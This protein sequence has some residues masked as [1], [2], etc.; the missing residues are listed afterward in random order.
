MSKIMA[1]ITITCRYGN[2]HIAQDELPTA[3]GVD[4]LIVLTLGAY[5]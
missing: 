1:E 3:H 5:L 2:I 4:T